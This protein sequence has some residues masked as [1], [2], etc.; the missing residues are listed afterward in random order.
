MRFLVLASDYDGTLAH[1]GRIDPATYAAIE[2]CRASGRKVILVTGRE[3]DDLQRVCQRIDLF[4]LVVA[5]NG[6]LLYFPAT[7]EERALAPAPPSEFCEALRARGVPVSCG[8]VIVATWVPHEKTVLETIHQ[9]GLE[10]QVIFNKG[11]VMVLPSGVNKASGLE[12]A[13][14]DLGLS[15]HEVVGVG[16]GENDHAFLGH[17]ELS[18]AVADA[19]PSL[20]DAADV[21]T[22]GAAGAGVV[23]LVEALLDDDARRLT[24]RRPR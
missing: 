7:R 23:E 2:R 16:D 19:V 17:C 15:R 4:D 21:V 1:D 8:R 5:E 22:R 3:L 24:P 13:L 14:A 9:F 20:A 12:F 10:L 6:A 11:A 18:V